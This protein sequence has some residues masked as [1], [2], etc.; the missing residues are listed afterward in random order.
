[1][2]YKK[3]LNND[4]FK[5][6]EFNQFKL[7]INDFEKINKYNFLHIGI[8]ER[9]YIYSG[10]SI[11]SPMIK[12]KNISVIDYQYINMANHRKG[13]QNDWIKNIDFNFLTANHKIVDCLNDFKFSFKNLDCDFLLMPNIIHHCSDFPLLI[14]KII[15][16]FPKLKFLYLFDSPLRETHQYPYDFARQTPNSID[17]IMKKNSFKKVYSND[18]GNA[19]DVLLYFI[20]QSNKILEKKVNRKIFDNI[21]KIEPLLKKNRNQKKWQNLGRSYAKLFTA[22]SMIYKKNS[23][24]RI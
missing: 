19:F 12:S 21:K 1:M 5:I 14:R 16:I 13:Y 6:D 8:I 20:S 18:I 10:K 15:K 2:N 24:G 23:N 17:N 7:L 22:Y 4:I 9:S 11:F 3:F